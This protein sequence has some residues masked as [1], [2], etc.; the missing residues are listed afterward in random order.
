VSER[1]RGGI[2]EVLSGFVRRV[3]EFVRQIVEWIVTVVFRRPNSCADIPNRPP[4]Y[5]PNPDRCND[6]VVTALDAAGA[7]VVYSGRSIPETLVKQQSGIKGFDGASRFVSTFAPATT[8]IVRAAHFG[9]PAQIEAFESTG[10]SAGVQTMAPT[11]AVEQGF[12]FTGSSLG[13]VVV[14]SP[15]D[16][17]VIELCH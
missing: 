2:V 7:L 13:R 9:Q 11:P 10:Q 15:G 4:G 16:T 3:V 5:G 1:D 14:T 6:F 8:V 12:N 17:I